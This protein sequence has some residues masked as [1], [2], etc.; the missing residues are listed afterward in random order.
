MTKVENKKCPDCGYEI[1]EKISKIGCCFY[2]GWNLDHARISQ[3][4]ELLKDNIV[5]LQGFL[6]QLVKQIDEVED[7]VHH[8]FDNPIKKIIKKEVGSK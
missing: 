1:S 7:E 8:R 4:I 3:K 5:F 6:N 2:C